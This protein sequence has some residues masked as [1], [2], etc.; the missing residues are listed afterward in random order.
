MFNNLD[1]ALNGSLTET[2]SAYERAVMRKAFTAF[3][4]ICGTSAYQVVKALIDVN[5]IL[6]TLI[7]NFEPEGEGLLQDLGRRFLTLR[8]EDFK[9]VN[10]YANEYRRCVRDFAA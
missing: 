9:N 2:S 3:K 5:E 7:T 8:L 6:A 1:G 4:H 10:D